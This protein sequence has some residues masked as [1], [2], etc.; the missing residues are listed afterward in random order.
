MKTK[1]L[2]GHRRP[3]DEKLFY[4]TTA[5]SSPNF[6]AL[7]SDHNAD[8][9]VVG[10]GLT[11]V[12]TALHLAKSGISVALLEAQKIGCGASG[13]NGGH[14][15]NG[16]SCELTKMEK[17]LGFEATRMLWQMVDSYLVDMDQNILTHDI[18]CDILYF[19]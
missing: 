12:S 2:L 3:A 9:C 5:C 1:V 19:R 6:S 16:F 11:G 15:A 10:G 14:I 18:Q 4:Y 17:M 13:R 8:V 7:E